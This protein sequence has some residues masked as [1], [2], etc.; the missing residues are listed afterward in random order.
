VI[1]CALSNHACLVPQSVDPIVD[2]PHPPPRFDVGSIPDYLLAPVL[3]LYRQGPAD[4][5]STPPCHCQL[6]LSIPFVVED[7]PTVS[8]EVRW[9]VDYDPAVTSSKNVWKSVPLPGDF[10]NPG[11]VRQ[12]TPF[13]FDA[14]ALTI[15]TDGVHVV[16]AVMAETAAWDTSSV[17]LRNRAV[18]P[19]YASAVYRFFVNVKY[20][21]D[22]TRPHCLQA[23][24]SVRVCQ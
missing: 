8:L 17:I 2:V 23:G 9:F 16:E 5:T 3:Q 21:P 11:T 12:L 14:D 10:N 24:A 7:D 20:S 22:S 4:Q 18:L 13:T 6:E 1:V 15:V 19:G